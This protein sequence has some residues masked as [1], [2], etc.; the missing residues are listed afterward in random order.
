MEPEAVMRTWPSRCR[1][2]E[3]AVKSMKELPS[4]TTARAFTL[5][6]LL[7]VIAI[8][9]ILASLL[10]PA[11]SGA[12]AKAT[13][14]AC[15]SNLRQIGLAWEIY[16]GDH[17]DRF[18]DRRDLKVSLGY[19]PWSSWP[20]SDPRGGWSA[21]VLSNELANAG[22]WE[23]PGALKRAVLDVDQA[24]QD[25]F[26]NGPVVRYWL[27]RFDRIEDPVPLDNFWAK[28]R[29]AILRDLREADNPVVGLPESIS[30]VEFA[31]DVYFPAAAPTV[32]DA[33]KGYAAHAR[34]R[35]RLWLDGHVTWNRDDRLR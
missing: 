35:N 5:I 14:T 16:L 11:L 27:W 18:P 25:S 22:V 13:A 31:V 21:V 7:V 10:L 15:R 23:C 29:S 26:T 28:R 4:R 3:P 17:D 2:P 30:D 33:L 1:P 6:E 32:D 12:K 20:P 24:R 8:I 19:R 34:G 9:A